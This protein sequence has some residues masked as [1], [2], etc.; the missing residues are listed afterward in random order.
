MEVKINQ[1]LFAG[2]LL[3][4]KQ[5]SLPSINTLTSFMRTP[6]VSGPNSHSETRTM[7]RRSNKL[8]NIPSSL[9]SSFNDLSES[10]QMQ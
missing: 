7:M 1:D 5:N 10:I 6:R 3:Y 2:Q 8:P 4:N 9:M